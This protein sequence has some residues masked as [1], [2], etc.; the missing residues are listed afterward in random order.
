VRVGV[1]G[2]GPIAH[3]AHLPVLTSIPGVEVAV[4]EP[5]RDRMNLTARMFPLTWSTPELDTLLRD[6]GCDVLVVMVPHQ[7]MF[8]VTLRCLR[9]GLPTLLEK[10]PG[11]SA[12]SARR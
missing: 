6:G 10:P 9:T 2:A 11:M 7:H 5:D 1:V 8:E 3:T 12:A 4:C